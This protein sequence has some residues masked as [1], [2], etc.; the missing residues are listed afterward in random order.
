MTTLNINLTQWQH[1]FLQNKTQYLSTIGGLGC[2]KTFI[3]AVFIWLQCHKYP[4]CYGWVCNNTNVQTRSSTYRA[5]QDFLLEHNIPHQFKGADHLHFPNGSVVKFQSLRVPMGELKGSE[6]DFLAVDEADVMFDVEKWKYVKARVRG[7]LGSRQVRVFGNPTTKFHWM[8]KEFRAPTNLEGHAFQQIST[9]DNSVEKGGFLEP[10]VIRNY[11]VDNPPGS[12]EHDRWMLGKIVPMDGVAFPQ[13]DEEI[14]VIKPED[15]PDQGE[16]VYGQDLGFNDPHV[17][18][19]GKLGVKDIL[20]IT[21]EYI[22]SDMDI[23]LHLPYL[24]AMYDHSGGAALFSDHSATQ[25]SIMQRDGF[26]MVKAHKDV[27]EGIGMLRKRIIKRKLMISTDCPNTI[28]DFGLYR[29]D[30]LPSGK[31]VYGKGTN[32]KFSHCIDS[33][34]YIVAG[35]DRES[36]FDGV[37]F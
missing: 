33:I 13:F 4:G 2:G 8:V 30:T 6:L 11:E 32:H 7:K 10:A 21:R 36:V 19:E 17:L 1:D 26:N 27:D 18:I 37:A 20:Y 9:Y 31:E 25:H 23:V 14:H 29:C 15:I 3:L 24:H 34:R 12:R 28:R 22:K 5:M 16:W 35:L